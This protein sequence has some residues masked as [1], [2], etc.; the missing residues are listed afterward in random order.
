MCVACSNMIFIAQHYERWRL[1]IALE[2]YSSRL[3]HLKKDENMLAKDLECVAKLY[4][5][6]FVSRY[7]H[8]NFF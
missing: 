1:C 7:Y 4:S 3:C 6:I 8:T 5:V 2:I